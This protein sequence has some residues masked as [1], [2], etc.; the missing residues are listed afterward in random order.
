MGGRVGSGQWLVAHVDFH[1]PRPPGR[2]AA[3]RRGTGQSKAAPP[4][5]G[6]AAVAGFLFNTAS[7][8]WKVGYHVVQELEQKG[9]RRIGKDRTKTTERRCG[10]VE[11]EISLSTKIIRLLLWE[12]RSSSGR[13]G[14]ALKEGSESVDEEA[15]MGVWY[16]SR[17]SDLV[18]VE[19]SQG[20]KMESWIRGDLIGAGAFGKVNL[21]LNRE[22][23]EL[24]AVK[25]IECNERNTSEMLAMKNEVAIL[26]SL[27]SPYVVKCL[28]SSYSLE[29]G[30]SMH[31]VFVEYMSGGSL[32]DLMKKFG[33]HF[34][35]PLI[36][37]YTRSI[38]QGIHYLH[39]RHIVHCDIKGKNV[40]VGSS[41][42]KL[43]D[44]GAAKRMDNT[45]NLVDDSS[46]SQL[47]T[48][49]GT[50]LWMAP[51]VVSL[52]EQGPASDIWSLGCTVLEMATGKAPWIHI[53][54][55]AANPFVALYHIHRSEEVPELPSCL[56]EQAHDFLRKCFQRDPRVRSTAEEL[57][58]H[59]FITEMY[60]PGVQQRQQQPPTSPTSTLDFPSASSTSQ[61]QHQ[62]AT[63]DISSQ[64]V[65]SVPILK[66]PLFAK[67]VEAPAVA[68]PCC[69]N[70][71]PEQQQS[72]SSKGGAADWWC[73]SPL[74]PMP[75]QW[76][77]VRSPKAA[78]SSATSCDSPSKPQQQQQVEKTY[79]SSSSVP[80]ISVER[81]EVA[82]EPTALATDSC[83][84]QQEVEEKSGNE[85][86]EACI[87]D[88]SV[89]Q[90]ISDLVEEEEECEATTTS[91]PSDDD[92]DEEEV[93]NI[94]IETQLEDNARRSRSSANACS[95]SGGCDGDDPWC[96]SHTES[97]ELRSSSSGRNSRSVMIL[98]LVSTLMR[99]VP[100]PLK[101]LASSR[102]KLATA[103]RKMT[104]RGDDQHRSLGMMLMRFSVYKQVHEL[105][106]NRLSALGRS[107][108]TLS[109][110]RNSKGVVSVV[111][112]L[113]PWWEYGDYRTEGGEYA[114]MCDARE[115]VMVSER[116]KV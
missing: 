67:R 11:E 61:Q 68:A 86:D 37:K 13:E 105:L 90:F 87:D 74:S 83:S 42:V 88:E 4:T 19:S 56:S 110:F 70:F 106:F 107:L 65:N 6:A 93:V 99:R 58:K 10:R 50:P 12:E 45:D 47:T 27:D 1:L 49:K 28:G 62:D 72:T 114:R 5:G 35:E 59:S 39:Q 3:V 95:T 31:N 64:I 15:E 76:I 23:G 30:K 24:F 98:H 75:G 18:V 109:S 57:L 53:A 79:C 8:E 89:Q 36:R 44:F 101:L 111:V 116:R 22:N 103:H 77:V 92:D 60:T 113:A 34:D 46:S 85:E 9:R 38:L 25:S 84:Q 112:E 21:A 20:M 97:S 40:L 100:W 55:G 73:N 66:S 91:T 102:R 32:A 26:A 16:S 43:A 48:M 96:D 33:G 29:N 115:G 51:E 52:A 82:V 104:S 81:E 108:P 54:N 69:L 41:G 80:L 2:P 17:T 14:N 94:D 63:G 78:T 71:Q 7:F